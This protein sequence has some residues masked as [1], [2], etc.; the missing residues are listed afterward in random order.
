MLT[1]ATGLGCNKDSSGKGKQVGCGW[2]WGKPLK[3]KQVG[4]GW[5]WRK[6]KPLGERQT[7]EVQEEA[8]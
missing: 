6:G 3:G 4:C 8:I 1:S 2:E 5:G 7:S